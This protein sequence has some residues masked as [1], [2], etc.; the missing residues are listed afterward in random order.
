MARYT[1]HTP[2]IPPHPLLSSYVLNY[3]LMGYCRKLVSKPLK[4]DL[5][6]EY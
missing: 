2:T 4:K 1:K 5:V 6:E 3:P